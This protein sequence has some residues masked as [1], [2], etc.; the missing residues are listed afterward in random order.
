MEYSQEIIDK[1]F[2]YKTITD[3]EK[4]DNDEIIKE[5]DQKITLIPKTVL[6]L[7]WA[8]MQATDLATRVAPDARRL[9]DEVQLLLLTA[10][11][12]GGTL[13]GTQRAAGALLGV[14][15]EGDEL[16]TAQ[17]RAGTPVDVRLVLVAEIPQRGEHRIGG[18]L[19]ESAEA[20]GAHL[21]RQALE[22]L[23]VGALAA[24]DLYNGE[25]PAAG[26]I[27]GV[28]VNGTNGNGAIIGD[29][30]GCASLFGDAADGYTT[31]TNHV[32]DLV[33]M[34]LDRNQARCKL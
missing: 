3:K 18:G 31:L 26:I 32:T 19:A 22:F 8:V 1:I 2:S 6:G 10:D 12:V 11:A 14:D 4:I 23:E 7:I 15:P 9:V 13:L 34:D 16:G 5:T 24:Y 29:I 30:D 17:R 20:A 28:L 25:A 27:T 33:R 21:V